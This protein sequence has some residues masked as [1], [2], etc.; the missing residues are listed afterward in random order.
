V[1]VCPSPLVILLKVILTVIG[2][3]NI[4]SMVAIAVLIVASIAA[5]LGSLVIVLSNVALIVRPAEMAS[6][7]LASAA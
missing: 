6:D 5:A 7:S 1:S 4:D 3:E 2:S